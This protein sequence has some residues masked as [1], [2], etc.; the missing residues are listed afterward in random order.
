MALRP[1]AI[2]MRVSLPVGGE[3][4]SVVVS[5]KVFLSLRTKEAKIARER[6]PLAL[7][8]LNVFFESLGHPPQALGRADVRALAGEIYEQAISDIDH[9]E[10]VADEVEAYRDA[11]A[12]ATAHHLSAGKSEKIAELEAA[13]EMPGERALLAWGLKHGDP[14]ISREELLERYFGPM[15]DDLI[16]RYQ[17]RVDAATRTK[18]L[19]AAEQLGQ[20]FIETAERRLK[21]FDYSD[22]VG[23]KLPGFLPPPRQPQAQPQRSSRRENLVTVDALFQRWKEAHA[24]KRAPSTFRRYGPSI[25][26]LQ[27]FWGERDVR[28]LTQ[29]D[30]WAWALEREKLPGVS[31]ETINKN[32]L[33]AVSSVL[34]WATK[35]PGGRLLKENPAV[36]VSLEPDKKTKKDD[37]YFS[38]EEVAAI[39]KAARA[40][41]PNPRYPR[42]AA[43]R[44]WTSWICAYTGARI[45]EVC[46]LKRDD[47]KIKDGIWVIHFAKTKTDVERTIPIHDALVDEGLLAFREKAPAGYLFVGDTPQK[48]GSTRTQQ[49]QRAS[50]LAEWT[51]EQ[52]ELDEDLSPNHG[53]RHTF[54]TRAEEANIKK[55]YINAICGHNHGKDV[56][57]RY[58]SARPKAL[59]IR[60]DAYPRYD[61]DA[62]SDAEQT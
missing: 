27:A 8:A 24:E 47:I 41:R 39:L 14:Q 55:R 31:A 40:A 30:I 58:F 46:W 36:G 59:K 48:P 17:M 61:L 4:Y 12:E 9:D 52:V 5:D 62:H 6:F 34:G 15:V 44:R 38:D 43:S 56:S 42:A 53:W 29:D 57:D 23:D 1:L 45:Q 20:D 26:S 7:N 37:K 35:H 60:I 10:A 28:L 21:N 19:N 51:R 33:V 22:P 49:E 32:D 54:I 11:F 13:I 25:A 18:L 50:E 3:Q 16:A 2:G